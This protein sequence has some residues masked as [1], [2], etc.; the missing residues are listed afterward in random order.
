M[1]LIGTKQENYYLQ[2]SGA[3]RDLRGWM[4]PESS[5]ADRQSGRG[6]ARRFGRCMIGT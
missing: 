1:G 6:A 2:V 3:W 5:H 4:L